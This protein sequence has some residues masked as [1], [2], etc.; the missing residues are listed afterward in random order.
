MKPFVNEPILELRRAPHR[1]RL[2]DALAELDREL[3]I[4]VAGVDR[5][6]PARRRRARLAPIPGDPDRVVARRRDR[7]ARRGRRGGRAAARRRRWAETPVARARRRSS[8]APRRSCASA[9]AAL[10]ALAVRECAKPW[11]EADADVC[12]AIDFLEYYA[13]EARRAAGPRPAAAPAARAS[14]TSCATSP[15][16]SCAV[17]APWNFPLAI[18]LGMTAAALATGNPAIL[19]PAEQSPGCAAEL[20]E[21]LREAGVPADARRAAAR[22]RRRRRGARR[23]TRASR[24]SRSPAAARSA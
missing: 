23:A 22:R 18:P 6:R 19:K 14:A 3:P 10:A 24:R 7:D 20:V 2:L 4:S 1:Q 12:E 11:A 9:R 16:A 15:A 5:R 13:R 17:I 21:A 8:S